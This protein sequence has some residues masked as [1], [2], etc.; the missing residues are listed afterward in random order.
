[1]ARLVLHIGTHKTGTTMIQ[2]R[3]A[4]ARADLA[5]QGVIYPDAGRHTG[6][7]SLLTDW[8]A[9]PPPYQTPGGGISGLRALAD[10]WR[11][12]DATLLLSSE[13]FSRAGGPG[14]RVDFAL[15]RSLFQGYAMRVICV[16]RCQWQFLQ[17]VYLE[18]QQ[19]VPPPRPSALVSGALECG[20][21]DG[22]WCDYLNLYDGL[23]ETFDPEEI[24]LI[25][26]AAATA[27]T[28]GLMTQLLH[29]AAP[30]ATAPS[31]PPD[32]PRANAS[33]P[34]IPVWAAHVVAGG[35]SPGWDIRRAAQ[36][37]YDLEYGPDR[38]GCIFTRREVQALHDR[39]RNRNDRL[40]NRVRSVQPG[41]H[42]P[43]RPPPETTL[44]REDIA[45]DYWIRLAR[46]LALCRTLDAA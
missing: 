4:A 20:Q 1:M 8:I 26:Y 21:V 46:R 7:H 42:L 5:G 40:A 29:H 23:R 32:A 30:R 12:T 31:P 44:Y 22:L 43:T 2:N 13:E 14:G 15:L 28:D 6:H 18:L 10:R 19:T 35:P 9:L 36:E 17:S 39:F 38:P 11:D 25:D 33:P 34:P 3:L 45:P 27:Q 24:R 37:A 16:L 41:W